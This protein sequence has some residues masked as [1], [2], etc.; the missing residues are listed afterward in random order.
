MF[1]YEQWN[2]YYLSVIF[3]WVTDYCKTRIIITNE[4]KEKDDRDE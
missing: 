2:K 1:K 4:A 3:N